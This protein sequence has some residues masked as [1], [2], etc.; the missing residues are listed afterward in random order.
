[1]LPG[2]G[3]YHRESQQG[4]TGLEAEMTGFVYFILPK[5]QSTGGVKIGY[6][7]CPEKRLVRVQKDAILRLKLLG[8]VPGTRSDERR[9]HSFLCTQRMYGEWFATTSNVHR[10]IREILASGVIPNQISRRVW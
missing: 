10:F 5:A 4:R 9:L 6:S 2:Q 8:Y 1:M 7:K 3:I